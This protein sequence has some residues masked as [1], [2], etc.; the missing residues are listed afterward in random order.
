MYIVPSPRFFQEIY[1]F[2]FSNNDVLIFI[3]NAGIKIL[4]I[5]WIKSI[6]MLIV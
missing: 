1:D 5:S 2:Y 4:H 3:S 6:V